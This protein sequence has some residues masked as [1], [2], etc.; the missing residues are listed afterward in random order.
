MAVAAAFGIT[1]EP[2]FLTTVE[3]ASLLRTTKASIDN[4]CSRGQL[5]FIKL[6][7]QRLFP[8]DT[9]ISEV[10]ANLKER[11]ASY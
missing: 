2:T 10:M 5:S 1:Q 7:K 4:L 3:V 6:G 9:L 8:R 11:A